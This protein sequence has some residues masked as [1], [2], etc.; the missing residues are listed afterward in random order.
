MIVVVITDKYI[1]ILWCKYMR[2]I[3]IVKMLANI[4]FGWIIKGSGKKTEATL[5]IW[6]L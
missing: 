3:I 1:K 2:V 6:V 5:C 4:S